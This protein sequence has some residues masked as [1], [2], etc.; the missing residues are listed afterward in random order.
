MQ[1]VLWGSTSTK[2]P[3]YSDIKYVTE[4]IARPT[5]NT[6]P[7]KTLLAF[8]DHGNVQEAFGASSGDAPQILSRLKSLGID[9][10]IVCQDLL[11]DGVKAFEDAFEALLNA[12]EKKAAQLCRK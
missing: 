2:N 6:I 5:V 4:L 8:L 3:Q 10:D 1:R 7:E 9:I 12:I 11:R